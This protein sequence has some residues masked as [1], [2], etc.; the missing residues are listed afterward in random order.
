MGIKSSDRASFKRVMAASIE[1]R[2]IW[3][4]SVA[5]TLRHSSS[6]LSWYH[7]PTLVRSFEL[8]DQ[9]DFARWQLPSKAVA[10]PLRMGRSGGNARRDAT[11][12]LQ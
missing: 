3:F 10:A 8:L 1:Q 2:S 4:F 12:H 5:A 11:I 7:D 6:E 9:S